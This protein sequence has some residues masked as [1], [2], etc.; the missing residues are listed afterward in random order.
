MATYTYFIDFENTGGFAGANDNIGSRVLADTDIT[1]ERG[2]DQI[3]AL[4]PPMAGTASLEVDNTS[5][6]YSYEYATSPIYGKVLPNR[7]LR[8]KATKDAT[9]YNLFLGFLDDIVH[10]SEIEKRTVEFP[11]LGTMS[12]MKGQKV[13]TALYQNIRTDQA[14]SYLLDAVRWPNYSAAGDDKWDTGQWGTFVWG[15]DGW[16]NALRDLDT[17][18]TTLDWW[19]VADADP[20]DALVE[21]LNTEGPGAALYEDGAG[22][23]HFESRWYR[24][25]T[26]RAISTQATYYDTANYTPYYSAINYDPRLK[27]IINSCTID[28]ITRQ[29]EAEQVVWELGSTVSLGP[30]ESR[31]YQVRT[32]NPFQNAVS[33]SPYTDFTVTSGS[34]A[35]ITLDRSSG[36][37]ATIIVTAGSQGCEVTDLQLRA[38][39]VTEVTTTKVSNTVSNTTS[40]QTYGQREYTPGMRREIAISVAQDLA[41]AVV[42]MYQNPRPIVE[43]TMIGGDS[44]ALGQ[45]LGREISDR[46]TVVNTEIGLNTDVMVDRIA[47]AIHYGGNLHETTFGCET[48]SDIRFML[49]GTHTWGADTNAGV[50][51]Y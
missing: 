6:D 44:T 30:N 38:Q 29:V 13:S 34:T 40:I 23:I 19:W 36:A 28:V 50:W 31:E 12:R 43:I 33:P 21:L 35:N 41:N 2:K 1:I 37:A 9:P 15:S 11:C 26:N 18:Q 4:A 22:K 42:V 45:C 27:D 7:Q 49:W 14:I 5:R 16:P 3:R 17:G 25:I 47:H 46:V 10:H 20:F 48:V 8:I 24:N 39:P 32:G 51:G